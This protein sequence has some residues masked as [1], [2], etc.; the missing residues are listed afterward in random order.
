MK[1]S[2]LFLA[3]AV[4]QGAF[5]G[6]IMTS[7]STELLALNGKQVKSS[8]FGSDKLEV[9]DGQHQIVVKYVNTFNDDLVESKPYIM[10][11]TV[12]AE[13]T[14][15]SQGFNNRSQATR[16]MNS[17]L[18]WYEST[19]TGKKII[20]DATILPSS[21]FMPYSDIEAVVAKFNQE[22]NLSIPSNNLPSEATVS[23]TKNT[24]IEQYKLS[25]KEQKKAFKLWLIETET[26]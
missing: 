5:A 13:T 2:T 4:S 16:K 3:L 21:G 6:E 22:N 14:I 25:S 1:I 8:F 19:P 12:N 17:D 24:L 7:N 15:S 20:A 11:I 10:T 23:E 26:K 9:A 18:V